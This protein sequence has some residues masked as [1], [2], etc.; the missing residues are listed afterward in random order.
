MFSTTTAWSLVGTTPNTQSAKLAIH[1]GVAVRELKAAGVGLCPKFAG[2]CPGRCES[3]H[4]WPSW[5]VG[6]CGKTPSEEVPTNDD[7]FA[8]KAPALAGEALLLRA[9]SWDCEC[10]HVSF[11]QPRYS[12]SH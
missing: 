9:R 6:P 2:M 1:P 3:L 10:Q 4:C 5:S 7:G 8:L 11:S 12:N